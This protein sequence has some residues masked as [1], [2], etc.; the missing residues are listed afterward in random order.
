MLGFKL[1]VLFECGRHGIHA[2]GHIRKFVLVIQRYP[3]FQQALAQHVRSLHQFIHGAA[4]CPCKVERGPQSQQGQGQG[5]ADPEPANPIQRGVGRQTFALHC[6]TFAGDALGDQ[7]T[8]VTAF[9]FVKDLGEGV[10]AQPGGHV[11]G[12]G[13]ELHQGLA[14]L[15][16]VVAQYLQGVC[17]GGVFFAVAAVQTQCCGFLSQQRQLA[18]ALLHLLQ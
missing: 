15:V 3:M 13:F 9:R 6:G 2:A 8:Q 11:G 7:F 5:H 16:N 1:L 18:Q 10:P 17:A 4:K 14:Q 12:Q